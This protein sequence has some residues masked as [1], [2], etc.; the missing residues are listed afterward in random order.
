MEPNY[1]CLINY[2]MY[3]LHSEQHKASSM[4]L[5]LSLMLTK[6]VV[7]QKMVHESRVWVKT[8]GE[9]PYFTETQ[10]PL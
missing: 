9:Y 6:L 7:E 4:I 8:M 1:S 5:M 2:S 3:C 10:T